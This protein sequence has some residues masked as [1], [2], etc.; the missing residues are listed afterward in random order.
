MGKKRLW[1][2]GS[3]RRQTEGRKTAPAA[4]AAWTGVG[5]PG[6]MPRKIPPSAAADSGGMRRAKGVYRLAQCL[7]PALVLAHQTNSDLQGGELVLVVLMICLF[8]QPPPGPLDGFRANFASISAELD[9]DFQVGEFHDD[10]WRPWEEPLPKFVETRPDDRIVGH[11]A[12]DGRAEYYLVSSPPDLLDR[13]RKA[14]P[15]GA[16]GKVSYGFSVV[17]KTEFL[18]DGET[19]CW[20]QDDPHRFTNS[21]NRNWISVMAEP[22]GENPRFSN[23]KGPFFWGFGAFPHLL[24]K[25]RGIVPDRHRIVKSGPPVGCGSLQANQSCKRFSV[26]AGII[27]RSLGRLPAEVRP[28]SRLQRRK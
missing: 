11:W 12:C 9:Y 22:I 16:V 19:V 21:S 18:W 23:V 4:P 1:G 25:Y 17:P 2:F 20:H 26:A 27:L 13:A 14:V 10:D 28:L 24:E 8:L 7:G 15:K 3:N 5:N 6:S